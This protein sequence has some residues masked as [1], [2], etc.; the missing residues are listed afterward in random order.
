[1]LVTH[2][3]YLHA[4]LPLSVPLA[5]ELLHDAVRP[6][7]VQLERLGGVAQVGAMHHVLKDLKQTS[8]C[9][10]QHPLLFFKLEIHIR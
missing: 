9:S 7:A 10:V 1:M 4:P 2:G 3:A 8:A 6:L 5:E